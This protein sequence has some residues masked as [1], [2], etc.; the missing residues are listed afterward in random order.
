[1][2]LVKNNK[3]LTLLE[4]IVSFALLGIV[5]LAVVGLVSTGANSYRAVNT[6][7][8]LQYESQLA[9]N[10][11]REY[12]IDCNGGLFWDN[13]ARALYIA[14]RSTDE[15]GA[16]VTTVHRFQQDGAQIN[17]SSG[18]VALADGAA[19]CDFGDDYLLCSYVKDFYVSR[20]TE[21]SPSGQR[22]CVSCTVSLA[23]ELGARSYAAEEVLSMR[24]P[25]LTR[26]ENYQAWL[27]MVAGR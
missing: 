23:L 19:S 10:Q 25:V 4:L 27:N 8:S 14:D 7:V 21:N 22:L 15:R 9:M 1:M 17:Y 20:A 6:E 13:D 26:S 24:N 11:F 3:G 18:T 16:A 2:K 5:S 12:L